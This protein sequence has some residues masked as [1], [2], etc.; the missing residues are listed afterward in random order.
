MR[1]DA[2]DVAT[3]VIEALLEAV[4]SAAN[5][6]LVEGDLHQLLSAAVRSETA[7]GNRGS[8]V[9]SDGEDVSRL[10]LLI[11]QAE[12]KLDRLSHTL[13]AAGQST[14]LNGLPSV[15]TLLNRPLSDPG[16]VVVL[17]PADPRHRPVSHTIG[18]Q[19]LGTSPLR[20][21]AA[22]MLALALAIVL[23]GIVQRNWGDWLSQHQLVVLALLGTTWWAVLAAG[24]A[25][26]LV[27]I[28]AGVIAARRVLLARFRPPETELRI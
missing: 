13:P 22:L 23:P 3:L 7:A 10:P 11:D 20:W 5:D 24:G 2:V 21:L 18:I 16:F 14:S 8:T 26:F 4:Q 1:C 19:L 6:G 27:L 25:G 28:L 17:P 9:P 15:F 12:E